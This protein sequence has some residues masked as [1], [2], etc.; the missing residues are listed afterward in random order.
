[1]DFIFRVLDFIEFEEQGGDLLIDY[2]LAK[3]FIV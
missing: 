2:K 3:S 1:M